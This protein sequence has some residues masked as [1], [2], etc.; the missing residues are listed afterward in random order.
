MHTPPVSSPPFF[1]WLANNWAKFSGKRV[2]WRSIG[3][4]ITHLEEELSKHRD[5]GLEIVR[6]SPKERTIP[7]YAGEDAIIRFYKDPEEYKDWT[8]EKKTLINFT[9]SLKQRGDHCGYN[10]FLKVSEGFNRKV[11]GVGNEALGD[12]WGGQVSHEEQKQILRENR[13]YWYYGTAPASYTLG[14][15]EAM[16]T[17]IP[18]VAAGKNFTKKLYP[19]QDTNEIE[20]IIQNGVNGF[21]SNDIGQL[22]EYI[23]KLMEDDELAKKIGDAG[24]KRAIELFGKQKIASEWE[25]LLNKNE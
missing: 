12:L 5:R 1:P 18:V 19:E 20:D 4:N 10:T 16:M 8:G 9:Q 14:L 3:Q 21:V 2:I 11:Y 15:M 6:Y 25:A 17:G 22:R 13:V 23:K 24:R 7:S